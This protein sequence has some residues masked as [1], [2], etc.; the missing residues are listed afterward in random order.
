M[1]IFEELNLRRFLNAEDTF[2]ANGASCMPE[3]VYRAM[4]EISGAW[5]DLEQM[6]GRSA[7]T[8]DAQRS[9]LCFGGGRERSDALCCHSNQRRGAGD[10][11]RSPRFLPV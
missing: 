4:R 8:S 7:G 6:H 1:S 2:T 9:R 10:V 3:E 11:S 5:V